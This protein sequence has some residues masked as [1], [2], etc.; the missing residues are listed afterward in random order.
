VL[1]RPRPCAA[2]QGNIMFAEHLVRDHWTLAQCSACI[3][4]SRE[5]A[6][7]MGTFRSTPAHP[8]RQDLLLRL[9]ARKFFQTT[10]TK[11]ARSRGTTWAVLTMGGLFTMS[12]ENAVDNISR[13]DPEAHSAPPPEPCLL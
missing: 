1:A 4:E 10:T 7:R 3:S 11:C 2:F 12:V 8:V 6:G 13:P 5:E 9:S